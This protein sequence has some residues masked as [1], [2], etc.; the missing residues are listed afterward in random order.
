MVQKNSI[1]YDCIILVGPTAVGKSNY[2]M[3]LA[4]EYDGEIVNADSQQIYKDLC[5]GTAKVTPND[6]QGIPHHLFDFVNP[7]DEF[8]VAQYKELCNKCILDIK[9]RGKMPI[10]VGG[11]GFYIQ[12]LLY[13]MSYGNTSKNEM[14]RNNYEILLKQ[15]GNQYLYDL[16]KSRDY[17]RA[18]QLHPNDVKRVIRA[19]EIFDNGQLPS[20]VTKSKTKLNAYMIMLQMDRV[21][22]YERI[23]KRVDNMINDGLLNEIKQLLK[24]GVTFN[25]Q[26]MKAIGYKEWK[27]YF[28]D[29][30]TLEQTIELIKKNTRNYAK[31]QI[32]WFKNSFEY[33]EIINL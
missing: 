31:R 17:D 28:E 16:L 26:C 2:A 18:K 6:M 5:I 7:F 29:K 1:N 33:N 14:I 23:N 13:D 4:K 21:K 25:N 10:I 27:D 30:L 15:N 24:K 32:T 22:L 12:S 19:L 3:Q 11:T 20:K 8:S 9:S